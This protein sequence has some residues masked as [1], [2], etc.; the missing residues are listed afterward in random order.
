MFKF[1]GMDLY[2]AWIQAKVGQ[3]G[4]HCIQWNIASIYVV[5]IEVFEIFV[6]M[7]YDW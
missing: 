1:V 7:S 3:Q 6:Y 2:E 5:Y 4:S